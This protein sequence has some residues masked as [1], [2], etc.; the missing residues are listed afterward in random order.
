MQQ[1]TPEQIEANW[2]KL[3]KLCETT[4]GDRAQAA[5]D[6]CDCISERLALAPASSKLSHHC[7]FPGGLVE[8]SLRV[9]NVAYQLVKA[10]NMNVNRQSL[11][12][13]ALF[14]D[15]GKLGYAE[16]GTD[17]YVP[18]DS[19]WHR[20]KLGEMYKTNNDIQFM[21]VPHRSLFILQEFGVKLTSEEYVA[22]MVHD[23]FSL[24]ENKKYMLKEPML[25]TILSNADYISTMQEK[26]AFKSEQ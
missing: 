23:G 21:T 12:L 19:Q 25:A 20:D 26:E 17:Y 4:L 14:H 11:V 16:E 22:I 2:N 15:L 10:T 7:A 8:H 3:L 9:L 6:M 18:Q 13:V 5:L 1:L 24:D